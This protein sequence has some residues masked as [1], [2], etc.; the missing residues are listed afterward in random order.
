MFRSDPALARVI[1]GAMALARS[2]G[3]PRVGSEHLLLMLLPEHRDVLA[4]AVREAGPRGAGAA[5]DRSLL[6]PLGLAHLVD[7]TDLDRPPTR[8]PLF[9]LGGAAAR[10]RCAALNP[11]LG[12]DAQAAYEASLRLALARRDRVH[13]PEHLVLA[14]LAL[15]PGVSWVLTQAGI[16]RDALLT[17]R[18]AA[19][20]PPRRNPLLRLERRIGRRV[21]HN[22]IIR[23]YQHTTGRVVS[24]GLAAL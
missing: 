21:R 13:R 4:D 12:L 17:E 3:H 19:F 20:P 22:D 6:E 18:A 10:R 23:R 11:P 9:P 1:D 15:D 14:L 24:V 7:L 5:A 2:L 16:S 8:E